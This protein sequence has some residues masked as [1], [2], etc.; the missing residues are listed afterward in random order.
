MRGEVRRAVAEDIPALALA[1]RMADIRE[2]QSSHGHTPEQ[3]FSASLAASTAAWTGLV[4]GVPV[5]MFGVGP[6]AILAGRGAPWMLGTEALDGMP[7]KF[8]RRVFMPAC[9]EAVKA[10]LSVYPY[11]ENFV[12]DRNATSKRWLARLGFKLD[13]DPVT[14]PNGVKF[15]HFSMQGGA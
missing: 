15:R 13:A 5:C 7:R 11:L 8:V 3:A 4:D 1:M 2:V 10:M 6:I 12:D 14:L 9:R